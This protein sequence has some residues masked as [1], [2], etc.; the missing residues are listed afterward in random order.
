MAAGQYSD[1]RFVG[2][3]VRELRDHYWT[4]M[5]G[6]RNAATE[7]RKHLA[8]KGEL[9]L[10]GDLKEAG[11]EN[12]ISRLPHQ[13]TGPQKILQS[14]IAKQWEIKRSVTS[15]GFGA[16]SVATRLEQPL[17]AIMKDDKAGF[18]W[19]AA[20][21]LIL[22]EGLA[23]G[24]VQLAT[25]SWSSWPTLYQPGTDTLEPQALEKRFAI[26]AQGRLRGDEGYDAA[27]V[28][29]DRANRLRLDE[30]H[31]TMAR[32]LPF[33]QR[34]YSIRQCA[35]IWGDD[36]TLEGLIVEKW[37]TP[38]EL[39]RRKVYFSK[40]KT[41]AQ[42]YP[43][44]AVEEGDPSNGA[45]SRIKVTEAWLTDEDGLPY[46]SLCGH[47]AGGAALYSWRESDGDLEPW[48]I[49]LSQIG[50]E[51]GPK[52]ALTRLPIS[53]AWGLGWPAADF[54][55]RAMAFI[56]PYL[57]SW[58]NLD[59]LMTAIIVFAQWRAFPALVEE[60][61]IG[62]Q[63]MASLDDDEPDTPDLGFMKITKVRGKITEIGSQGIA[64][65]ILQAMSILNGETKA[66]TPGGD[67]GNLE[68]G[69][70]MS[71][72]QAFS[73]DA[74][75][76]V[77]ESVLDMASM[78]ASYVL[79][80]AKLLGQAYDEPVRVYQLADVL[81]EQKKPSPTRQ[82]LTLDPELI[83]DSYDV[84]AVN[85][86]V[87]GE[88]PAVRQQNAGL[89]KEGF[90]S[91]R[92]F[93]E[94]DGYPS[95]EAMQQEVMWE[96]ALESEPGMAATFRLLEQFVSDTFTQQIVD[97]ITAGS[98]NPQTGLPTGYAQGLA[99]PPPDLLQSGPQAGQMPGL[100]TPNPAA[101]ALAGQVGAGLQTS[102]IQRAASAG[103][104]VPANLAGG[105]A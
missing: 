92:W 3:V 2:P 38:Q 101:S 10:P 39:I 29:L 16:S 22:N 24:T 30:R 12:W 37:F 48:T 91:K 103:G 93:L 49:D 62:A 42:L 1:R 58:K 81:V 13:W 97:A 46:I 51:H 28:N 56:A 70:A 9:V 77:H 36:L 35:P 66:E 26:D 32:N 17:H 98:A 54:D 34:A 21:D 104:V 43:L 44:G 19:R 15:G 8:M 33:R 65:G 95:P 11:A 80:G 40:D 82:L 18:P 6:T 27:T 7:A 75:T 47:D 50:P 57:Q 99:G 84:K 14:C 61:A 102:A 74:L 55:E 89:V 63:A 23:F 78:H 85:V 96:R 76:T 59:S 90:Y 86:K 64:P 31:D 83:G 71:L 73:N 100:S 72:N 52:L 88:N 41:R 60:D 25:A 68:T 67:A 94:N 5:Q 69:F 105:P 87:P 53:W 45:S 79:E 4:L 20:N